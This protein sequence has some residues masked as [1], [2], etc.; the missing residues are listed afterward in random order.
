VPTCEEMRR[1]AGTA[2]AVMI[3]LAAGAIAW[4][5]VGR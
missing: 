5:V 4:V 1:S 2:N 3:A